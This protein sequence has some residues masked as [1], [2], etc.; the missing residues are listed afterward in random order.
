M[1]EILEKYQKRCFII[2]R[3]SSE[4]QER[5]HKHHFNVYAPNITSDHDQMNVN[6]FNL[7][8]VIASLILSPLYI[9]RGNVET[10]ILNW[11][12]K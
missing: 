10:I 9:I 7:F 1:G 11:Y 4:A 12:A 8:G 3:N 5:Q 2:V 6:R